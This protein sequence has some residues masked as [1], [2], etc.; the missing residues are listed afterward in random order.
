M[1][2]LL[3]VYH[4]SNE[5][6]KKTSE[7]LFMS[8]AKPF[9]FRALSPHHP[10]PMDLDYL[11]RVVEAA[12]TYGY[13][14]I[15]ICGDTHDGGNL[16][17]ITEFK[18]FPRANQVQD[19]EGVRR[20]RE[21]LQKTCKA[22]HAFGMKV[23]FW[24][25]ELWFPSRLEEVY[26]NWFVEAPRNAFTRDLYVTRVPRVTPDAPIWE[27]MDAKFDEAFDQCPELDG[28]VMTIQESQVPVYCLFDDFEQQVEALVDQYRRLEVAHARV[29]REWLIRS[30]AWREHE[31]R[32]VTEAIQRW[33]PK[34]PVESKGV[35]MDWH[36]WYPYDPLLGK[37]KGMVN[38]VEIAP[39]C[40]FYGALRHPVGHP[41]YYTENLRFAAECGHT[42]ASLRLDRVGLSVLGGPDEGVLAAVGRW[43]Q[44]PG[45][46][47]TDAVYCEWIAGRYGLSADDAGLFFRGIMENCWEAT[48]HTYYHD[49]IYIGD[50]TSL[51]YDRNFFVAERHCAV[52]YD[53]PAP[54]AEKEQ[55]VAAAQ[56]ALA[57]LASLRG[58]LKPADHADLDYRLNSLELVAR[59]FRALVAALVARQRQMYEPSPD[60]LEAALT[61]SRTLDALGDEADRRFPDWNQWPGGPESHVNQ[62]HWLF[63]PRARAF[64]EALRKDLE[65]LPVRRLVSRLTANDLGVN[66]THRDRSAWQ[67]ETV[68]RRL[69]FQGQPG[70][71]H[72]LVVFA[73]TEMCVRR[74]LVVRS[75]TWSER[76]NIGQYAWF[77]AHDRFR[78]YECALPADCFD[79]QGRCELEFSIPEPD[80]APYLAEVRLE[81]NVSKKGNDELYIAG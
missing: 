21:I 3:Y 35:P 62:G 64:A 63:A 46:T 16:D 11:L 75:G 37:F 47:D 31:Y 8:V 27:Y 9:V 60:H 19:R 69:T 22:A 14:A 32:V 10:T 67:P 43:M 28:T 74:P 81:M 59:F 15:Q 6:G 18:R 36:L 51:G 34:V 79:S 33:Q 61:V 17:G 78:R 56:R 48:C 49:K 20:R 30:F 2:R 76:F 7:D 26:P 50:A 53:D 65:T 41:H 54:L 45:G 29:G 5:F 77:L 42:G 44:D 72:I 25:H 12:R 23:F 58:Q 70:A 73:G 4:F 13:N 57:V 55:A 52:E 71:K 39:S 40:E 38:H 24:H 68:P 80:R 1:A 66:A